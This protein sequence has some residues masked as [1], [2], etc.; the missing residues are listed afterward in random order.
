MTDE[1]KQVIR[2]KERDQKRKYREKVKDRSQAETSTSLMRPQV[3]GRLMNRVREVLTEP[4]DRNKIVL[5]SLLNESSF[6][7]HPTSYSS[8]KRLPE[9]T[10]AKV[11]SFYLDDDISRA[12]PNIT[13]KEGGEKKRLSLKHVLYTIQIKTLESQSFLTSSLQN[14]YQ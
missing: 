2:D 1:E 10:I 13:I 9:T 8:S 6:E 14:S 12:S 4:E 3:K 5:T 7:A 11:K